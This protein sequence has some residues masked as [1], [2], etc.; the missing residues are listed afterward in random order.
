MG[1]TSGPCQCAY[2][3]FQSLQV[4]LSPVLGSLPTKYASQCPAEWRGAL[5]GYLYL[6]VLLNSNPP[7]DLLCP[8]LSTLSPE[9]RESTGFLLRSPSWNVAQKRPQGDH[10]DS[11]SL[12]SF[13]S[14]LVGVTNHCLTC[15]I[16]KTIVSLNLSDI[17]L[18]FFFFFPDRPAIS[19]PIMP[20]WPEVNPQSVS[21]SSYSYLHGPLHCIGVGVLHFLTNLVFSDFL[22]VFRTQLV[23]IKI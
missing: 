11:I 3:V 6:S 20:S 23:H 14:L 12:F 22:I 5:H 19:V 4:I 17:F 9:L 13:V 21:E 16:L 8:S 7:C 15:S 1:I 18:F 2:S 10:R